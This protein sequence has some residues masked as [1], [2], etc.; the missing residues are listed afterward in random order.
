[1]IPRVMIVCKGKWG[2][3]TY[4]NLKGLGVGDV[5]MVELEDPISIDA[6]VDVPSL[7]A[8][9]VFSYAL[10]PEL[11]LEVV[12]MAAD[13]GAQAVM[14]AGG[15]KYVPYPEAERIAAAH[16]M[17][18]HVHEVCCS[19]SPEQTKSPALKQVLSK[20]GSPVLRLDCSQ[21]RVWDVEVV[22]GAPCGSTWFMAQ[23]LRGV[24][25]EQAP[26][27]A[28]LLV[29]YYPCRASRGTK[30]GIHSSSELHLEAVK[31]AIEEQCPTP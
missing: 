30:G 3:R 8:D 19:L 2:R 21:G 7:V 12:R 15:H 14:I 22:R 13:G 20:V 4:N 31:R 11:N 9:V 5:E 10:S 25:L 1:M 6:P 23:G 18:L 28:S 29:S 26:Q 24:K 17:E 16:G 27:E